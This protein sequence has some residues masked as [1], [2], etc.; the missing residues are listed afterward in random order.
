MTRVTAWW[1]TRGAS[2]LGPGPAV[3]EGG[4]PEQ[5]G[6]LCRSS[7]LG[8]G[9]GNSAS[10]GATVPAALRDPASG[11]DTRHRAPSAW[12]GAFVCPKL[13]GRSGADGVESERFAGW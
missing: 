12:K 6:A 8:Q 3:E 1:E 7:E 2:R 4:A 10:D 11:T 13:H 5:G 9:W